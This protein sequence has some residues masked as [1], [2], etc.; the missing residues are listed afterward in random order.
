[1]QSTGTQR[2][3]VQQR[4]SGLKQ[5]SEGA[6]SFDVGPL[7][8]AGAGLV[9]IATA[10]LLW[11]RR[12]QRQ[13]LENDRRR[14]RE[15]EMARRKRRAA[16]SSQDSRF[17]LGEAVTEPARQPCPAAT[18]TELGRDQQALVWT[19]DLTEPIREV[20]IAGAGPSP[21]QLVSAPLRQSG[22]AWLAAR[23]AGAYVLYPVV[24]SQGPHPEPD[25]VT[26]HPNGSG[27][28]F[29]Q[30]GR[31]PSDLRATISPLDAS[32][33]PMDERVAPVRLT[34]MGIGSAQVEGPFPQTRGEH[35]ALNI[36]LPE[37][38]RCTL[39]NVRIQG[40]TRDDQGRDV[41]NVIFS[42]MEPAALATLLR[43]LAHDTAP[44]VPA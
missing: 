43:S 1:M 10:A 37:E 31:G 22:P 33:T 24:L 19:D 8:L 5:A 14:R 34:S 7:F 20:T 44:V 23:R 30:R 9:V 39:V 18:L 17:R 25:T 27:F 13:R 21:L 2:I 6:T 4:F 28:R 42:P 16:E 26:A 12:A 11:Q 3:D 38:P 40:R 35:A 41:A 15:D 32:G 36:A 29:P